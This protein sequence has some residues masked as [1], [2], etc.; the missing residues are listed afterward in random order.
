[1]AVSY[2]NRIH[3]A[4]VGGEEDTS[5]SN[6]YVIDGHTFG[7]AQSTIQI[8]MFSI[9]KKN[10]KEV[11]RAIYHFLKGKTIEDLDAR[12]GTFGWCEEVT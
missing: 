9:P 10:E 2:T 4:G 6:Y 12:E 1:M 5:I 7:F 8:G 3:I 11:T